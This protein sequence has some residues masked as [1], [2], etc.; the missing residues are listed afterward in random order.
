MT[1]LGGSISQMGDP[2]RRN[3]RFRALFAGTRFARSRGVGVLRSAGTALAVVSLGAGLVAF[4]PESTPNAAP[5]SLATAT[6][7]SSTTTPPPHRPRIHSLVGEVVEIQPADRKLIVR[8]TLRDGSPKTTTF[9]TTPK[10]VV[11]RGADSATLADVHANDHVTIKYR[12]DKE[13]HK[14]AVTIRITPSAAP[15]LP[16]VPK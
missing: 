12:E 15:K 16:K 2:P 8:E 4:A 3:R 5:T 14:E 13:K 11:V 7:A 1:H 9:S 10:T 6:G